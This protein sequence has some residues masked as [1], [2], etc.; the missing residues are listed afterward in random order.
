MK[1]YHTHSDL[2]SKSNESDAGFLKTQLFEKR[3]DILPNGQDVFP[4]I[5]FVPRWKAFFCFRHA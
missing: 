5:R 1:D 4:F 3:K 2:D